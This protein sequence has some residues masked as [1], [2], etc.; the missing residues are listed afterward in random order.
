MVS[1]V[2]CPTPVWT[3]SEGIEKFLFNI[4]NTEPVQAENILSML[5]VHIP[6]CSKD[7]FLDFFVILFFDLTSLDSVPPQLFQT[8]VLPG[9]LRGQPHII[10]QRDDTK[11]LTF[12]L[13]HWGFLSRTL[14]FK[15][16]V[17]SRKVLR[18]I[19][20]KFSMLFL[21]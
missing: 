1:Q 20:H 12:Q 14:D 2:F 6:A 5:P 19:F 17:I 4:P 13:Y 8:R 7:Q 18:K 3:T 15:T 9:I 11:F 10:L 21:C 16:S